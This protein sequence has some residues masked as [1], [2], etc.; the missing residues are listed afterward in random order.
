MRSPKCCKV[1]NTR[2][3]TKT[4]DLMISKGAE[5]DQLKAAIKAQEEMRQQY[6]QV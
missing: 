5:I 1:K 4:R 3:S 2:N 6:Q